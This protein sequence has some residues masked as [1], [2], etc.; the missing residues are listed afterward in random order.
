MAPQEVTAR[1]K[2]EGLVEKFECEQV[3]GVVFQ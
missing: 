3:S 2:I 1:V